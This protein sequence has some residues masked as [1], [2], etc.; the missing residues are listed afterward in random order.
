MVVDLTFLQECRQEWIGDPVLGYYCDSD[1]VCQSHF[2]ASDRDNPRCDMSVNRCIHVRIS[3]QMSFTRCLVDRM[4]A[5][6]RAAIHITVAQP[7]D[8]FT[9]TANVTKEGLYDSL[10]TYIT[11]TGPQCV[12]PYGPFSSRSPYLRG[13][14]PQDNDACRA[15]SGQCLTGNTCDYPL[16]V[17]RREKA[18]L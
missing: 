17:S 4:S 11:T 5:A 16:Q 9:A 3:M 15:C 13:V 6:F 10:Y 12:S 7:S 1:E 18:T 14:T 2:N 8:T